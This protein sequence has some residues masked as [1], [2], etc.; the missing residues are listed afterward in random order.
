VGHISLVIA[1]I[2]ANIQW[3]VWGAVA[4]I[5]SHG[6]LRSALF[7]AADISY[8]ISN[9]RRLLLNKG[10]NIIIPSMSILWF[11]ISAANIAAPPS[12]NLIAEIVLI[13]S[14]AIASKLTLIPL[15]IIRFTAAAYSLTL[16]VRLN[17]GPLN[18]LHNPALTLVPR[19]LLII[20]G[21]IAPIVIVILNPSLI[22]L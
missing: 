19:N 17:H 1:G 20:V 16:Y 21:H 2:L 15:G 10:L 13:T 6:L 4:I 3:G 22:V 8:S 5:I 11:I 7:A 12:C 14:A 9:S 18:T